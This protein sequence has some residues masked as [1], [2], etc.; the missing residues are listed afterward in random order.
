MIILKTLRKKLVTAGFTPNQQQ[1]DHQKWNLRQ[2][3]FVALCVV[4]IIVVSVQIFLVTN[5]IDE[6]IDAIVSLTCVTGI[7]IAY[8]SFIFKNEEIFNI[9]EICAKEVN[10]SKCNQLQLY[11]LLA[12]R[13]K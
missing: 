1:N 12:A 6:Y 4:N 9:I 8:V 11:L 3:I 5:E 13:P 7:T 10:N 2:I